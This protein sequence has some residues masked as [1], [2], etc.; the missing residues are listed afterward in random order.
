MNKQEA[1]WESQYQ[2]AI[3]AL[4]EIAR[5]LLDEDSFEKADEALAIIKSLEYLHR[6]VVYPSD[7]L[8]DDDLIKGVF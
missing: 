1:S 5:H 3:M 6:S 2:Q 8:E 7:I 4:K